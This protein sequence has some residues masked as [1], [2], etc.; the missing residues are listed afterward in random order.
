M[1][2]YSLQSC[3][4]KHT[5]R[6]II[7]KTASALAADRATKT[8]VVVV[9]Q[10]IFIASVAIAI[11]RTAA[12]ADDSLTSDTVFI[13]VEAHS[14]AFS[15]LYFWV[16]PAVALASIIGVSQ[17]EVS[18]PNKLSGLVNDL[19]K[20]SLLTGKMKSSFEALNHYLQ[21]TNRRIYHGGIYSWQ[22]AR[23]QDLKS[24]VSR[25]SHVTQNDYQGDVEAAPHNRPSDG[26][27]RA[28]KAKILL[29]LPYLM[30][31]LGTAAGMAVSALVPPDGF[32]CRHAAQLTILAIWLL[33]AGLNT[34]LD[35]MF[36]LK[37]S[38]GHEILKNRRRLF[39]CTY[40]KD[41]FAT[42]TTLGCVIATQIGIFNRCAC[43][44]QWAR[45]GLQLPEMPDVSSVLHRRLG[46][47][48]PLIVFSA[49]VIELLIV[50]A[51]IWLWYKDAMTVFIQRDD[52]E[53]NGASLRV[54]SNA[55]RRAGSGVV[56]GFNSV[57]RRVCDVFRTMKSASQAICKLAQ[58]LLP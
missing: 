42:F 6:P 36:P 16:V 57:R 44:T 28:F 52:G 40:A 3:E 31:L 38:Q 24:Q 48:Y 10:S 33:S 32:D 37:T 50:P 39:W 45:T 43:Y 19:D 58:Y 27:Q 4:D 20:S 8:V 25:R 41:L 11:L 1:K 51:A 47:E 55:I 7:W 18:I 9:A 14:I 49:I 5:L 35:K 29:I 2:R 17:S 53:S 13:N 30:V 34:A 15:A 22:P 21:D 54:L 56:D 26:R 46:R 23:R 12:A